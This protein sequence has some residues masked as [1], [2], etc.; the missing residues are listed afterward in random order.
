MA[1]GRPKDVD[2]VCTGIGVVGCAVRAVTD[3]ADAAATTAR[4]GAATFAVLAGNG[5]TNA[6]VM[7]EKKEK[8]V[9]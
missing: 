5:T 7:M 9:S 4:L 1:T 2:A 8:K 3:G 6:S